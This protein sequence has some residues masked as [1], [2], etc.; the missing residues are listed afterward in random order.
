VCADANLAS[1]TGP[2]P[3]TLIAMPSDSGQCIFIPP[4]QRLIANPDSVEAVFW[5]SDDDWSNA[6]RATFWAAQ[7]AIALLNSLGYT[8]A[9]TKLQAEI[10]PP[11]GAFCN[12]QRGDARVRGFSRPFAVLSADNLTCPTTP[13]SCESDADCVK[14]QCVGPYWFGPQLQKICNPP[15]P[16]TP[17][18]KCA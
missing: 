4:V 7:G 8:A 12:Y 2:L 13:P 3:D 18:P 1:E 9:A 10:S 15:Q 6:A 5:E 11:S 16:N 14:G 17:K